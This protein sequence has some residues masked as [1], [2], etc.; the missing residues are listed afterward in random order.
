MAMLA[1]P[2]G[3][4]RVPRLLAGCSMGCESVTETT[5]LATGMTCILQAYPKEGLGTDVGHTMV[6]GAIPHL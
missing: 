4:H 5:V 1:A 6:K 3:H 2:P